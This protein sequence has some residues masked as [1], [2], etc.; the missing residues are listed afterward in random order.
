MYIY[1]Y[2]SD[3]QYGDNDRSEYEALEEPLDMTADSAS[4]VSY[5]DHVYYCIVTIVYFCS[6][7]EF[8]IHDEELEFPEKTMVSLL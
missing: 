1:I 3:D 2:K 4:T 8:G 7:E 5:S 6:K